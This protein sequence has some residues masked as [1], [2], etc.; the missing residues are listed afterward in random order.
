MFLTLFHKEARNCIGSYSADSGA[1]DLEPAV[2]QKKV[3]KL[4]IASDSA[5][6][7]GLFGFYLNQIYQLMAT[8]MMGSAFL[9]TL[10][11]KVFDF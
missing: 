7:I 9:A 6:F 5:K 1:A 3:K 4:S 10:D 8:L 11:Q 2:K